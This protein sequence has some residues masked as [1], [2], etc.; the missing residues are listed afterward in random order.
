MKAVFT[1]ALTSARYLPAV[2]LLTLALWLLDS[3]KACSQTVYVTPE[4]AGERTGVDWA[5]ALP[6]EQLQPQL[7]AS[8]AGS[9]FRLAGGIYK[10][11]TTSDRLVS[12]T[13]PAGV[14]V[15]G[16]YMGIGANPDT[17]VNFSQARQ[18]SSTTLSGDIDSDNQL[19]S[20]NANNVVVFKNAGTVNSFSPT[21]LD[22]VVITG[23]PG[24][25]CY[26]LSGNYS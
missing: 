20:T 24:S 15:F 14:S 5:N 3:Q 19:N 8:T 17:R 25:K 18:P 22:G 23:V 11:T 7:A 12:F 6:G 2:A 16:G 1:N 10:P 26:Y 4:G 13:I 9:V 21:R